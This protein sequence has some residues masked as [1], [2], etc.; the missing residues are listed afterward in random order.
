MGAIARLE[1]RTPLLQSVA[2]LSIAYPAV[3]PASCVSRITSQSPTLRVL[4]VTISL[5]CTSLF[6][7]RLCSRSNWKSCHCRLH[8]T[9]SKPISIPP[10]RSVA[11]PVPLPPLHPTAS[12]HGGAIAVSTVILQVPRPLLPLARL[13]HRLTCRVAPLVVSAGRV[14]QN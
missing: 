10:S 11:N 6:C 3:A 14:H 8:R 9:S 2:A 12:S 7:L 4:F 1:P 13:A 5:S